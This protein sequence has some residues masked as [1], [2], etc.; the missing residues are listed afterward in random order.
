MEERVGSGG[1]RGGMEERGEMEEEM[2]ERK[3]SGGKRG[4][5]EK[6]T[7]WRKERGMEVRE[8]EWR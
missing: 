4:D 7:R 1:K 6:E 5:K 3:G 2:E 8:G